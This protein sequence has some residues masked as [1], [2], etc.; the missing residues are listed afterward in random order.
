[1]LVID[2]QWSRYIFIWNIKI[3]QTYQRL[4]TRNK[5]LIMDLRCLYSGL[6]NNLFSLFYQG[7][8]Q[9]A[10]MVRGK[11]IQKKIC[12]PS[13]PFLPEPLQLPAAC[14]RPQY[15][16][17]GRVSFWRTVV[18]EWRGF[19]G[20]TLEGWARCT[21]TTRTRRAAQ[22]TLRN[23]T[24]RRSAR[25]AGTR[26]FARTIS[27]N[28]VQMFLQCTNCQPLQW[29]CAPRMSLCLVTPQHRVMFGRLQSV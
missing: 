7:W 17:Q 24:S 15:Q 11:H 14:Q 16:D 8:K 28:A 19:W 26:R 4:V 29:H 25:Q 20:V 22:R 13:I 18:G 27:I 23:W 10:V 5:N 21:R 2:V 6:E 12:W 3:Y 1:M 9:A